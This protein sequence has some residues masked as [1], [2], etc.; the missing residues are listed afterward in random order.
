M[1]L[2]KRTLVPKKPAKTLSTDQ[3]LVYS[4][5][6]RAKL[7]AQGAHTVNFRCDPD[8]WDKLQRYKE[9][10]YKV[11]DVINYALEKLNDDT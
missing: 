11:V 4:Q 6:Y 5:R 7:K 3:R 8:N 9:E 2:K 10:G 1:P